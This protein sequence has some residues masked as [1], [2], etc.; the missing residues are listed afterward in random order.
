MSKRVHRF[1]PFAI[2]VSFHLKSSSA[3]M[4]SCGLTQVTYAKLSLFSTQ[5]QRRPLFSSSAPSPLYL[6]L[7]VTRIKLVVISLSTFLA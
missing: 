6:S 3:L 7:S 1:P 5:E 2:T 4:L